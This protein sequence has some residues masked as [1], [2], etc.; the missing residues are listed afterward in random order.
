MIQSTMQDSV[1][2][3]TDRSLEPIVLTDDQ[4]KIWH[5]NT[6]WEKMCGYTRDEVLGK[7]NKILQGP[8]T[9]MVKARRM[10]D[11]LISGQEEAH[12][13]LYNYKANGQGFWNDLYIYGYVHEDD[14]E[15]E[16]LPRPDYHVAF[17]GE[18]KS[19]QP[20]G[21]EIHLQS[22][23]SKEIFKLKRLIAQCC[24][25]HLVTM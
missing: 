7:T 6:A 8:K 25:A 19:E 2:K 22:E 23:R 15:D 11:A 24:E 12:V 14:A 18:M 17:L 21:D 4:G 20:T 1:K 9:D 3:F 13:Q 5:C 16:E 10:V